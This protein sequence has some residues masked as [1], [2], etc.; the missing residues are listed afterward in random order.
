[1]FY[2]DSN[3]AFSIKT[4]LRRKMPLSLLGNIKQHTPPCVTNTTLC[5]CS[6]GLT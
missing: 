4:L 6:F 1:M 5:S 2:V 3:V